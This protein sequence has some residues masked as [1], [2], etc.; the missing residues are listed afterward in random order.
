MD[1]QVHSTPWLSGP[2]W[3]YP[4]VRQT[5]PLP[6]S[7][8]PSRHHQTSS[9]L[10]LSCLKSDLAVPLKLHVIVSCCCWNQGWE[11]GMLGMK[12]SGH[13]L[14]IAPPHLAYGA[15]GVPNRVPANSTLIFEV[16]LQR[17]HLA[18]SSVPHLYRPSLHHSPPSSGE[19][20]SLFTSLN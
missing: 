7:L 13:R 6:P 20:I 12:K 5:D 15:K 4:P 8:P 19:N 17:V 1:Q 9:L 10:H 16:E 3:F 14:I 2:S 11:E 18:F